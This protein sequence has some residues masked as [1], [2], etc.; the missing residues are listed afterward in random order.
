ML[1]D[2][3]KKLYLHNVEIKAG[4]KVWHKTE[5][6]GTVA[7]LRAETFLVKFDKGTVGVFFEN[8]KEKEDEE[9]LLFWG[10]G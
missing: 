1:L 7:K 8:G 10:K 5:S 9:V 4:D 3:Y 2:D 6:W